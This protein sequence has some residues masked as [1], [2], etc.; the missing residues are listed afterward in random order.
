MVSNI[1]SLQ[2]LGRLLPSIPVTLVR[3]VQLALSLVLMILSVFFA[4]DFL[5]IG[6][7]PRDLMR[8]ARTSAA[9]SLAVQLSVYASIG[10]NQSIDRTLSRFVSQS[11][12]VLAASL[13]HADGS[14]IASHGEQ[15]ALNENY[16]FT[17][18]THLNFPIL[19]GEYEWG[20]VNVVYVSNGL[21]ASKFYR[22]AF[23]GIFSFISFVLF[24]G[25]ILNQLDPGRV[26]PSRVETAFDL[27][28]AGVVILDERSRIVLANKAVAELIGRSTRELTGQRMENW[29]WKE[30]EN[31]Q[32]PWATTLHSGLAVSDL[33]L[34]LT[35]A[36]GSTRIFSV[37]CASVGTESETRGVLVTLDDLTPIEHRNRRLSDALRELQISKENI[38]QKN[39][40]LEVLATTDPLTGLANRRTL[41][42]RLENGF[43]NAKEKGIPLSC[44]MSDIDHFKSVNDNYGHA[45]GDDVLKAVAEIL[46]RFCRDSDTVG[47]Y[48]GEEFVM[49]LPGLDAQAAVMV[50]ERIRVGVIA[51][52][53]GSRL[54]V[55]RLSSS[56]G[57]A[58][59]SWDPAGCSEL[60]DA[61]DQ[62]LYLAKQSGRNRVEIYSA[63]TSESSKPD[64]ADGFDQSNIVQPSNEDMMMARIIELETLLSERD[65]DIKSLSEFDTLTGVPM[66]T[67]FLQ[68]V[69]TE[70]IR[71][72]RRGTM[73]GVLSFELRNLERIVSSFGHAATDALVIEFV[74][75]LQDGLR[76]TDVVTNL[77]SE[78]S[79]SRITSN[80]YGVLLSDLVDSAS[81]MIVVTRLKR[82]LSQPFR[83]GKERVYVGANIGIALSGPED[84]EAMSL[85]RK[86]SEARTISA[87]KPDKVSHGFASAVLD[88]ASHD[89]IRLESDLNKALD[90]GE[91]EVWFQPK[92]DLA[93]RRITGMEA[94]L[95]W[96][97]ET[98]GFVSPSVF[99][100]V[101]EANG[102]IGRLS[103]LVLEQ[104]ISQIKRWQ[105]MGLDDLRIS[106]NVSPMQLRAN[107]LVADTLEALEKAGVDGKHLDIEL[108]ETSVIDQPE[109][110]RVALQKLRSKGIHI[111]MD[112]F[113]AG[114]TSLALLADLPLD[115]VKIDRSFI[116]A[117]TESE[118]NLSVVQ[119]I[120][121]MAHALK[122]R[123][124]GEGVETNEELEILSRFGC[125][126]VQGYLIS[127]PQSAEDITAF[128][129]HQRASEPGRR[130]A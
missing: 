93:E 122:L 60:V 115:N 24:L 120:I 95:R 21:I 7:D 128:L 28:S 66:L 42:Q 22:F 126:E 82:L 62:A 4:A 100:A 27:F 52:A 72:A 105:S 3:P 59:L 77:T 13:N 23:I 119:S 61:A 96:R 112:D 5:G 12:D 70:L 102:L 81:A 57:V 107:T 2:R 127:R 25:K 85:F 91:L 46:K 113:G 84:N 71:A 75:R 64:E 123:V 54:A 40:E 106:V 68:R 130:R 10:D 65:R 14:V 73:V 33:Q 76:T 38:S 90:E 94:L 63:D 99:I 56:F 78:H 26:V 32:A 49:V 108:T 88:D 124:V 118:R 74:E 37:S 9:E 129:V 51:A 101:A 34:R 104:T 109:D 125:D 83:I 116:S 36:D 47:R 29:S 31:W 69:K 89:Y 50:A 6:S 103:D 11:D 117:M 30:H 17:T 67:L 86:A 18:L 8:Q 98:R 110:A 80:E 20:E 48:G 121:T 111:S 79:M 55:P 44:I 92:F 41:M 1:C 114:Y 35:A 15:D 39:K 53:S 45:A 87:S 16:I 58:D 43:E 19:K 97:H